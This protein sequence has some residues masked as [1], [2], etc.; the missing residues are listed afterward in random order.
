MLRCKVQRSMR[1]RTE[2]RL[3]SACKALRL[4]ETLKAKGWYIGRATPLNPPLQA[5]EGS[6]AR[7]DPA[8]IPAL[9]FGVWDIS[10]QGR[11]QQVSQPLTC[12][13]LEAC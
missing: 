12:R 1:G 6:T 2:G 8:A 13:L 7:S 4:F 10:C 11:D 3:S 5:G 9:A